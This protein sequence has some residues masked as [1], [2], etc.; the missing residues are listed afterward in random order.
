MELPKYISPYP[1]DIQLMLHMLIQGPPGSGKTVAAATFPDPYWLA[2]ETGLFQQKDAILK[3]HGID[4][5]KFKI[6]PFYDDTFTRKFFEQEKLLKVEKKN[7]NTQ[8]LVLNRRDGVRLWLQR[9]AKD[10]PPG[11]TLV[12]DSW[13]AL[14]EYFDRMTETEPAYTKKGEIDEFDFWARKIEYSE[15]ICSLLEQLNCGVV[16]LCHEAPERDKSTGQLLDKIQPLQ[17]GKFVTKFKRYF[18]NCFRSSV[19]GDGRYVWQTKSDKQFDAKCSIVGLPNPIEAH[20]KSLIQ[21]PISS[22]K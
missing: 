15:A 20:Y 1:T 18:S 12:L 9:F 3:I 14:Q 19:T 21:Q 8:E 17:Q 6:I 4:V 2:C 16:V 22:T 10:I 13:T 11:S 5:T 7:P